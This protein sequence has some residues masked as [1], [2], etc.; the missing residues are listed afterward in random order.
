MNHQTRRRYNF[1]NLGGSIMNKIRGV[2]LFVVLGVLALPGYAQ[3][4]IFDKTADWG[5][6]DSPPQRGSYKVPGEVVVTGS[7][8]SA[9]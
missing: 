6:P 5:G 1:I 9:E 4:G 2:V 7:G 3:Y 8:A